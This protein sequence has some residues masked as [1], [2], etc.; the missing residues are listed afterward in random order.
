MEDF[1]R[2]SIESQLKRIRT[3][4]DIINR[5]FDRTPDRDAEEYK[6]FIQRVNVRTLVGYPREPAQIPCYSIM[7]GQ[8][9]EEPASLGEFMDDEFDEDLEDQAETVHESTV[10]VEF[11]VW[12]NQDTGEFYKRPFV[13]LPH[14]FVKSIENVTHNGNLVEN[15]EVS[16]GVLYF[17][18]STDPYMKEGDTVTINYTVYSGVSESYGTMFNSQYRIECWSDNGD[19]TS[20]MYYLLKFMMLRA[21]EDF[22]KSGVVIPTI[23]GGDLEPVPD[24]FPTFVYRRALNMSMKSESV[25]FIED[26]MVEGITVTGNYIKRNLSIKP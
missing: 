25:F 24:Y 7:L 1:I 10:E 11:D 13:I 23:S 9:S 26:E 5:L 21:R 17:P 14:Y 15:Y 18:E 20:F 12:S 8:E 22:L 2:E 19:I 3:N 16:S 6:D 4:P